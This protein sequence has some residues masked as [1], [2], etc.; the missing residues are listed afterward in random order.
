MSNVPASAALVVT[1]IMLGVSGLIE[2]ARS[3]LV[4][5]AALGL[6]NAAVRKIGGVSVNTVFVTGT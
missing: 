6:Q 5:A 1:A 3:T 2:N 4:S